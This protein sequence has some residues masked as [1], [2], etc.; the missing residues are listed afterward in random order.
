MHL[1][2]DTIIISVFQT[3][4]LT[5]PLI[6]NNIIAV[7]YMRGVCYVIRESATWIT[8]NNASPQCNYFPQQRHRHLANPN[9]DPFMDWMNTQIGLNVCVCAVIKSHLI[10]MQYVYIG[11][12]SNVTNAHTPA[13]ALV[14]ADHFNCPDE[15]DKL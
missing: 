9:N 3:Q 10:N 2:C 15:N 7:T 4:C 1:Q 12:K 11:Y 14:S 8:W 13:G 5:Y 6:A